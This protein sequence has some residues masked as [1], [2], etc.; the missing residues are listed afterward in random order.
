MTDLQR[1]KR[2]VLL[3]RRC[4]EV[5]EN[6]VEAA[7]SAASILAASPPDV[8]PWAQAML[9]TLDA[10]INRLRTHNDIALSH[11]YQEDQR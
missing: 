6:D 9:D 11:F 2:V 3:T 5:C 7:M 1:A 8:P 4:L 10:G